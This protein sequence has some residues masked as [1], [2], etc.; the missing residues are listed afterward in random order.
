MCFK[1]VSRRVVVFV[2]VSPFVIFEASIVCLL[3]V[4]HIFCFVL[5]SVVKVSLMKMRS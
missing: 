2:F 1:I 3:C 5:G 4:A